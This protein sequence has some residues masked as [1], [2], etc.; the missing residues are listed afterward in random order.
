MMKAVFLTH[1]AAPSGAELATLRLVTALPEHLE[2]AVVYTADGPMVAK[3]KARAI[4]THLVANDTDSATLT[5]ANASV[6]RLAAGLTRLIRLGW[7]LGRL[8]RELEA[9]VVVAESAKALVM[10]A[11]AAGRARIPLVWQVHDRISAEYFG[12]TLAPAIRAFGW[13]V[14]RGYIANSRST[15]G[16]LITWRRPAV[17]AYPG[18]EARPP[19]RREDQRPP[20]DTIVTVVGR[21]APWKG[22][23]LFL[24]ALADV[25]TRPRRVF[26]VG[27]ALF[28]EEAF[29][30]EL[31]RLATEFDLPVTFTGH[32]DEPDIY[33]YRSDVLVHCTL[34]AEPFGQ[35]VVEGMR[36]GCAVI[37]TRPGGPAEIVEPGVDGL[38][39]DGGDRGQL[40]DALN[41]LIEDRALRVRLAAAAR[42]R[43]RGFDIAESAR[44][45]AD[46]LASAPGKR[47]RRA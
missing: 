16:S 47:D 19:G 20:A 12:R 24:R 37:A 14:A 34:L 36:A 10:G 17:V 7:T 8:M 11:V 9:S 46:F 18:L 5:I 26:L 3:T 21:L 28:G 1:T 38:L 45:V 15:L 35:V 42:V 25:Q 41:T 29:R 6:P 13:L 40:T 30:A 2:T 23:E 44:V 4:E 33:L 22:Q 32:V 39:V 31:E 43:A 27:G